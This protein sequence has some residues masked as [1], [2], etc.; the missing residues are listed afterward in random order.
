MSDLR[1]SGVSVNSFAVGPQRD[2]Q[3]LAAL[4]N[5]TG[6]NLYIDTET[7]WPNEAEGITTQRALEENRR[8]GGVAGKMLAQWVRGE[9]VRPTTT[10]WPAVVAEAYPTQMPPLRSDRETVVVG[11]WVAGADT[12]RHGN[13]HCKA[14]GKSMAGRQTRPLRRWIFPTCRN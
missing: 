1:R 6:G 9:V 7:T 4:A 2:T 10:E 12:A 5:Q 3:L 14:G 11:K 8:R 13:C